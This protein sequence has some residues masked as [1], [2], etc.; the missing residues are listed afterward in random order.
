MDRFW[1]VTVIF[2]PAGYRSRLDNYYTFRERLEKQNVKL[3]TVELAF[4]DQEHSIPSG[5]RVLHLRSNSILWQKERLLNYAME[6]LPPECDMVGWIDSDLLLPD[7]WDEQVVN[8]LEKVD[9]VQ[10]FEKVVHLKQGDRRYAGE[11]ID[12]KQGIVWQSKLYGKNWLPYRQNRQIF[13][14]EPGYGWAAKRRAF[15]MTD[16]LYDRL[17]VGSGDNWLADCLLGSFQL[18][19]YLAKLTSHQKTDMDEWKLKFNTGTDKSVDYLPVEIYHLWHGSVKDRAYTT[20]DLIFKQFDFDPKKDIS[21]VDNVWEWS[22][23]KPGFH[24]AVVDYFRNRKEDG[25][26]NPQQ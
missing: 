17:I 6:N 18:H 19:H 21:M 24:R 16:G 9:F 20:R 4:N 3:L 10:L 11:R 15:Q 25:N 8:K 12:V 5:D 13:H 14:S 2:N 26:P 7:G 1:C 22:S 23:D